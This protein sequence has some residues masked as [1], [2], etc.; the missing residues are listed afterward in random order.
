MAR[1]VRERKGEEEE[2]EIDR[3]CSPPPKSTVNVD[4]DFLAHLLQHCAFPYGIFL[5]VNGDGKEG[6]GGEGR[7]EKF[8]LQWRSDHDHIGVLLNPP[9]LKVK[10]LN[11]SNSKAKKKPP[12]PLARFLS[13]SVVEF[14]CQN[15]FLFLIFEIEFFFPSRDKEG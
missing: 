2:E 7:G 3:L 15:F 13:Q 4:L 6:G 10:K 1:I 9:K 8:P 11:V 14:L 12:G 5:C